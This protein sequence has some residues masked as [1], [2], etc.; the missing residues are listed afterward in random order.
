M[1]RLMSVAARAARFPATKVRIVVMARTGANLAAS[2]WNG[3]VT[4]KNNVN[5]PAALD[6]VPSIAVVGVGAP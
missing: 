6:A 5:A 4:N 2:G 3:P 1:I